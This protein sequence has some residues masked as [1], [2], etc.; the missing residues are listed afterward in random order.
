MKINTIYF[1]VEAKCKKETRQ[2]PWGSINI[3]S[4]TQRL[5]NNNFN[6]VQKTKGNNGEWTKRKQENKARDSL[7]D[8]NY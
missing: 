4:S 6:E 1:G 3:G 2:C 7:K 5:Y 8:T